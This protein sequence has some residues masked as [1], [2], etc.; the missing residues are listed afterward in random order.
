MA[1]MWYSLS[2][3]AFVSG[4]VWLGLRFW[5][6]QL[7]DRARASVTHEDGRQIPGMTP[8]LLVGNLGYVYSAR[9]KLAAYNG[10]HRRFGD[11]VQIFWLWRQQLSI[12]NYR[13]AQ[14][15]LVQH[16]SKYEKFPPNSLLKRLYGTSVLTKN[17]ADWKRSRLLLNDVFTKQRV[18]SFHEIFV[19]YALQ[20]ADA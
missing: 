15:V 19:D 6:T 5:Y 11:I 16:Q 7:V 4:I 17:G 12:S 3:T 2:L 18:A 14:S 9:N 1:A 10:F 13:M 8:K 20:L